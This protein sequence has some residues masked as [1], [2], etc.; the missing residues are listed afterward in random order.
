MPSTVRLMRYAPSC[1]GGGVHVERL[2]AV[3]TQSERLVVEGEVADH[4]MTEPL[5][6]EGVLSHAVLV[7]P[8]PRLGGGFTQ[9]GDEARA[10]GITALPTAMTASREH[11]A[12]VAGRASR[13]P[14]PPPLTRER[15]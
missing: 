9:V 6:A 8:L 7:P 5:R 13:A 15:R 11:L 1:L 14:L 2:I 4:R 3:T 10:R 12:R